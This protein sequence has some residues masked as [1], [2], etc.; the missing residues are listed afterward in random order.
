MSPTHAPPHHRLPGAPDRTAP[1]WPPGA[2][3]AKGPDR[4][5]R[6]HL[7]PAVEVPLLVPADP[8]PARP[9]PADPTGPDGPG[10]RG[11]AA[12]PLVWHGEDPALGALLRDHAAAL[13][14]TLLDARSAAAEPSALPLAEILDAASL[15]RAGGR[16]STAPRL[17]LVPDTGGSLDEDLWRRAL[18]GGIRAVVRL[19]SGSEELLARLRA[20]DRPR[21]R[22]LVVGVVG[23]CG[24]AG[25]SSLAARLAAAARDRG[26]VV[27]LDADPLGGGL[28]LLVEDPGRPGLHWQDAA[29]LG[30][31]D[32]PSLR[33]ALPRTDDVSLLV[34]GTGPG[35][36][37]ALL[38]R[39]LGMLGNEE[40]TVVV[41]LDPAL[42]PTAA[43][44]LDRLLLVVPATEHAVRAAS[45]RLSH[46]EDGARAV[47]GPGAL[48]LVVRRAGPLH[49][50]LVAEDLGLPLAGAFRDGPS[51]SVPL[52]DVSRRGADRCCRAL[53]RRWTEAS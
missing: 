39:A 33:S 20:L 43:P 6:A 49:P 24:G 4:D 14:L 45:R 23:G 51:G 17:L 12:A 5:P 10:P 28:D 15:P 36:D 2:P 7:R 46:W 50:S 38:D 35:P 22:S 25:T 40:A 18:E 37:A 47:G 13:G 31:E 42:V 44:H 27:L 29:A 3:G 52:L 53:L 21:G 34:A 48:E 30:P 19:P 11:R 26:P 1:S 9:F 16:R 8:R 41:D 32:G